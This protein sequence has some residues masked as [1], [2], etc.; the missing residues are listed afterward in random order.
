MNADLENSLACIRV[1]KS[2]VNEEYE[3]GGLTEPMRRSVCRESAFRA[4][5]EY[6]SGLNFLTNILNVAVLG[7]GAWFMHIGQI[8]LADL[9]A[10]LMFI[11]FFLQPIRRLIS[12]TQQFE[13]GMS[14]FKRF[15]ELMEAKPSITEAP[16]AVEL[17]DVRGEIELV[18]VSFHYSDSN[19]VLNDISEDPSWQHHCIRR[20]IRGWQDHSLPSHPPVLRCGGGCYLGGW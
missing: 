17:Q 3:G 15:V 4:M 19:E 8:D 1:A 10:Y 2:F 5:A 11:S 7:A 14:G 9:T 12:F 6:S 16:D 20:P 18:N 13:Q